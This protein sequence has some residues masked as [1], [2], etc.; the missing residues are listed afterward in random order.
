MET[1]LIT[2]EDIQNLPQPIQ[3]FLD[4]SG[5]VGTPR[6]TMVSLEQT[7][8]FMTAPDR[9][10]VPFTATQ[11]YNIEKAS[12]KWKVHMKMAPLMIVKGVDRL[13][14][15]RGSMRIKLFGLIPL[16]SADGPEIDQ[17]AMTRYLSE[18]IWFPQAF[19]DDH[20]HWEAIDS[21][22]AKAI[23]TIQDKSVEG[24]FHFDDEGKVTL[25]ECERY[26]S[27]GKEMVLRTWHTPIDE[28]GELGGLQL[29]IRGRAIWKKPESDYTY[30]DVK[31]TNI[32]YE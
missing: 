32:I 10:W 26:A 17:G 7:G 4:Y 29:G 5:V 24:I 1:K 6:I 11:I 31:I 20:I 12:F 3:R 2:Q 18:T 30:I 14:E 13:E 23:F 19:L 25:F 28:Y 8:R 21:L 16:V 22:S 9:P 27:E 15:G